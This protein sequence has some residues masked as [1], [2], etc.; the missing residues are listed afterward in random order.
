[1]SHIKLSPYQQAAAVIRSCAGA[2]VLLTM[3]SWAGLW[4]GLPGRGTL[5]SCDMVATLLSLGVFTLT[6][7][8]HFSDYWQIAAVFFFSAS[9][10]V[11]AV[12]GLQLNSP[13]PL[14]V[15]V[16]LVPLIT[17]L[18]PWGWQFQL[19]ICSLCIG[20][21]LLALR[22]WPAA[23]EFGLLWIAAVGES[24]VAVLASLQLERQR[25]EQR[26]YVEALAADEEQF[27]ALI[28]NSPDGLT[29]MN[30]AGVI[31]FHSPSAIRL[32]GHQ[33]ALVG[34]S[35]Y[36][37]VRHD[38][39]PSLR[40]LFTDCLQH[41]DI[42]R[43]VSLSCRHVDGSWRT[44]EG[45][46][47]QLKN[48]GTDPLIVLNWRDVTDRVAQEVRIRESE[49]RFRKIFQYSTDAISISSRA[50]GRYLEVNDEWLRLLGYTREEVIGKEPLAIGIWAEPE[51]FV[52][53]VAEFL[54]KQEV[55]N[56]PTRFRTKNGSTLRGLLSAVML[57]TSGQELV[58]GMVSN[59]S[60][61]ELSPE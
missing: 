22:K 55:R 28:E 25:A 39:V 1:M 44:I 7:E 37:F 48:Y 21:T 49:E 23:Q 10:V 47:K 31:V 3:L 60:M 36:E 32:L 35:I 16:I 4:S 56:R 54:I 53:F 40:S 20:A 41:A 19:G 46:G 2:A 13:T 14:I 26:A 29:V 61:E 42:T 50:D 5:G 17:V 24:A 27:R 6:F 11:W 9:I 33:D 34:R 43:G 58:L 52:R 38:C 45:T 18:L 8:P 30:G 12:I 15:L 57:Q 51:D 59:V